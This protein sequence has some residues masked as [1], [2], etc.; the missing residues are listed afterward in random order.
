MVLATD[1]MGLGDSGPHAT[2]AGDQITGS[3][4]GTGTAQTGATPISTSV[5][6]GNATAGSTAFTLPKLAWP[7]ASEVSFFN[8]GNASALVFPPLG[9]ATLNASSSS[10][11]SVATNKGAIF[12]LVAGSGGSAPQWVGIVSA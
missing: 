2:L 8:V 10:S 12:M 1:L 5:Y 3:T 4:A 11:V 7:M 6:V 9:G